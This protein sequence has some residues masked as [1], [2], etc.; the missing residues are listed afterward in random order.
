MGVELRILSVKADEEDFL[1][2]S[3]LE[4]RLAFMQIENRSQIVRLALR[5]LDFATSTDER[6][7]QFLLTMQVMHRITSC[8]QM[9]LFEE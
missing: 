2:A 8:S 4:R 7:R 9:E 6:L 5:T 3:L 1:R